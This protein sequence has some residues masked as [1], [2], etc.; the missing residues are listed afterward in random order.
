MLE[1][2]EFLY[3]VGFFDALTTFLGCAENWK[4]VKAAGGLG[5][6]FRHSD[7]QPAIVQHADSAPYPCD[8]RKQVFP[9]EGGRWMLPP[10][11]ADLTITMERL[12]ACR[13]GGALS[14]L[15]EGKAL[16]RK[17]RTALASVQFVQTLPPLI[18][19][20]DAELERYF[21]AF[22]SGGEPPW[23][24][25][26][27]RWFAPAASETPFYRAVME[28]L[29]SC[30]GVYRQM[31]STPPID[32]LLV[33][34]LCAPVGCSA[35]AL[36]RED[37]HVHHLNYNLGPGTKL[38]LFVG[39]EHE[40]AVKALGQRLFGDRWPNCSNPLGHVSFFFSPQQLR[41]ANIPF[42]FHIQRRGEAVLTVGLHC[43]INLGATVCLVKEFCNVRAARE[44]K[45]LGKSTRCGCR[46]PTSYRF[47]DE[48]GSEYVEL[49]EAA[50]TS[51]IKLESQAHLR[52]DLRVP[53][54]CDRWDQPPID[55]DKINLD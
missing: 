45:R 16:P 8:R 49:S 34:G 19:E 37:E 9:C 32:A 31:S 23:W 7:L 54:K 47:T 53:Q 24:Y 42:R 55:L 27:F 12:V 33:R 25:Y 46:G 39:G 22:V 30:S 10:E 17:I 51:A 4:R 44:F 21:N 38:W 40:E 2:F 15:S 48:Q 29:E 28:M 18:G 26:G 43:G 35:F 20:S 50:H 6:R 11:L 1:F 3:V 36:H 41:E 5:I 13:S 14:Y 52:A